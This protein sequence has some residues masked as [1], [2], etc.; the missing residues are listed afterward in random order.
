MSQQEKPPANPK[1]LPK[2]PSKKFKPYLSRASSSTSSSS[3]SKSSSER[4]EAIKEKYNIRVPEGYYKDDPPQAGV[5]EINDTD[6]NDIAVDLVAGINNYNAIL[7]FANLFP[8]LVNFY[9][10]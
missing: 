2:N 9:Y 8:N 7:K 1:V 5:I 3:L 6:A 4:V 10:F